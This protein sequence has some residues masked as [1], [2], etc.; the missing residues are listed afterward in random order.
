MTRRYSALE[1][2]LVH[3]EQKL[4][5]PMKLHCRNAWS[6]LWLLIC[7]ST[8]VDYSWLLGGGELISA[9]IS[10]CR[11]SDQVQE[12]TIWRF[13]Q[14]CAH[15]PSVEHKFCFLIQS[16][17]LLP[18]GALNETYFPGAENICSKVSLINRVYWV[19]LSVQISV[20]WISVYR[21]PLWANS[22]SVIVLT[23]MMLLNNFLEVIS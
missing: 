14:K 18:D 16:C 23:V 15:N 3:F 10:L 6:L 13:M 11:W 17:L 20:M 8:P 9:V 22:S 1:V 19:N 12:E 7:Q 2:C 21:R 4:C 5:W